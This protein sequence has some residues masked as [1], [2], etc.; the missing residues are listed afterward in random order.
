MTEM[1]PI[2]R[3][4]KNNRSINLETIRE[5]SEV[6]KIYRLNIRYL[7][8]KLKK[9]ISKNEQINHAQKKHDV[10]HGRSVKYEKYPL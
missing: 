3:K 7:G 10:K 1:L 4:T 5:A 2:R 9:D 8:A 6:D